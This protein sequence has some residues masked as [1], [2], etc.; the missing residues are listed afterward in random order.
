MEGFVCDKGDEGCMYVWAI[1]LYVVR[2]GYSIDSSSIALVQGVWSSNIDLFKY[3]VQC[4]LTLNNH[5]CTFPKTV[6]S[7]PV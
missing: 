2:N 5:L 3:M 1:L 4:Q 6:A 7:V